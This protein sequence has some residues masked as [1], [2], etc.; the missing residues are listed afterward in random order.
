M[1]QQQTEQKMD[2][3]QAL[4]R[5]IELAD[6]LD[7]LQQ[8]HLTQGDTHERF[9]LLQDMAEEAEAALED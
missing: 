8:A 9:N 3:K 5:I 7:A 1:T 4:K 2:R 6:E